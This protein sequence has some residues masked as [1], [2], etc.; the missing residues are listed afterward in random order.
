MVE[1]G[2]VFDGLWSLES[3]MLYPRSISFTFPEQI[4]CTGY[5]E[6]NGTILSRAPPSTIAQIG[7]TTFHLSIISCACITSLTKYLLLAGGANNIDNVSE[8]GLA[9]LNAL[10]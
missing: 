3:N 9:I 4:S 7:K 1:R 2:A 8:D 10:G 5:L 6:C